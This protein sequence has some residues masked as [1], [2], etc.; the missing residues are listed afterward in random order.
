MEVSDEELVARAIASQ[1]PASFEILVRRHHSRVR[2]WLRHLSGDHALADDLAQDALVAAWRRLHTYRA[3]GRFSGWLMKIA[4]NCYLQSR[5]QQKRQRRIAEELHS[6]SG[7]VESTAA[8]D[9]PERLADLP[10][11]LSVLK[12]EE[13]TAMI[14]C[15]A[16]GYSHAEI[17]E[18]TDWPLGTVK[19]HIRRGKSKI[20]DKLQSSEGQ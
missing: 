19:S 7:T 20:L 3:T 4:Y 13:R 2:N 9:S 16:H 17:S 8:A 14:L 5:R 12:Q 1:D 11:F 18:I 10:K 15:Y 6:R